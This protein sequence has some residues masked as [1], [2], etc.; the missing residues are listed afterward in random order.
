MLT[1]ILVAAMLA[2]AP[3]TA[4]ADAATAPHVVISDYTFKSDSLTVCKGTTVTWKNSDDDPHT[5]TAYDGSFDSKGLGQGDT[6]T[7]TFDTVGSFRYYCKV[8]PYMK[9]VI[10]VKACP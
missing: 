8:H 3:A 4:P 5:V 2:V 7:N 1:A 6:Y 10:I 9:A